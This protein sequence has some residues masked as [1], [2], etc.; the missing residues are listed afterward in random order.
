MPVDER[1]R[2][3]VALLVRVLPFVAEENCFALKGGTAINLFIRN[4]P[5]LSVDI[6]L[7]YLPV[8][9]REDSLQDIETALCRIQER[10]EGS[11]RLARVQRGR[12]AEEGTINKLFV[13]ERITQ[14]KIEVTPVLRGCVMEP[15]ARSVADAVEQ[16]IGFAEI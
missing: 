3:Q 15:E 5:R 1:Y 6:D 7:A 16:Q 11:I 9:D 10:V 14:I 13:R 12:L 8:A 2:R 4:L